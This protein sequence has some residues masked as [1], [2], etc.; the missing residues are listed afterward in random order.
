MLVTASCLYGYGPTDA[1][2]VEGQADLATGTK[3]R[4]R[5]DMWAAARSAHEAGRLRAVEVRGADY[6]GPGVTTAHLPVVAA[7]AVTGRSV[8]VFGAAGAL[9]SYTDVRDM[10]RTMVAVA[11]RPDTH[12]QVWHAP[13]PPARSQSEAVA[14]VCRAAGVEPVKVGSWPSAMLVVGGWFMPFLREMR[15]TVYQFERDY[16]LDS[17]RTQATLGLAPTPWEDS[18]RATAAS[19]GAELPLPA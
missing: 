2:M 5:A 3:G 11:A 4:L 18:C 14:D 7:R 9:H 17:T 8:R 1:P 15:E 12:G 10:A 19:A 16:V 6:V 13:S